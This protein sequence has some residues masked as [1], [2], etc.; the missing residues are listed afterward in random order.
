MNRQQTLLNISKKISVVVFIIFRKVKREKSF[1]LLYA[2]CRWSD[3]DDEKNDV[4]DDVVRRVLKYLSNNTQQST[5]SLLGVIMQ[6]KIII[7]DAVLFECG[8][9]KA[10]NYYFLFLHPQKKAFVCMKKIVSNHYVRPQQ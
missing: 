4:D 1:I 10:K 3:Y 7:R 5:G 8:K 9:S 6:K 2:W